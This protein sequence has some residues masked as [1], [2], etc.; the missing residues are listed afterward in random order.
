MD[1]SKLTPMMQQ[2]FNIKKEYTDALLFFRL[3]DFYEMFFDDALVGSKALEI[4]LTRRDCGNGKKCPMC[5][6]PYHVAEEYIGKLVAKGFK[7]AIC[8]QIEDPALAKGI[9]ERKVIQTYSPGMTTDTTVLDSSKNNYLTAIFYNAF[10]FGLSYIDISTGELYFTEYINDLR[11]SYSVLIS[12]LSKISPS[13]LLLSEDLYHNKEFLDYLEHEHHAVINLMT[14]NEKASYEEVKKYLSV[15]LEKSTVKKTF[16]LMA[17]STL[18]EY[19]FR[20]HEGELIH[21]RE[22]KYYFI[23]SFMSIDS[24]SRK[25]LEIHQNLNTGDKRNTLISVLDKTNTSMGARLLSKY[26]ERPLIN[27]ESIVHRQEIIKGFVLTPMKMEKIR[28]ILK[29]I[30]DLERIMGKLSYARAN[31]KDLI[32]LKYSIEKLPVLKE[33]LVNYEHERIKHMGLKLDSLEDIYLLLDASIEDDPPITITEGGIIKSGFD[34]KLDKIRNASIVGREELIKYEKSER[35]KTGIRTLKIVYNKKTGYFIDVTK[36]NLS[37][38]PADYRKIQ[39]LTNSERFLSEKLTEIQDMIL[40]N[41]SETVLLEYEIFQKIRNTILTAYARIFNTASLIAEIDVYTNLAKVARDNH[42]IQPEIQ[43]NDTYEILDGRHPV[44]ECS[45]YSN[46]FIPNDCKIGDKDNR[47]HLITGPNMGGKSTYMRQNALL[48]IMAQIGSFIPADYAS[49]SITDKIFTR[50]GASDNLSQGESTF[51][52]EMK[53]MSYILSEATKHSFLILDEIGRGTSTYDGLSIAWSILEYLSKKIKAKTLFAT[54]YHELTDLEETLFNVKNKRVDVIE[55]QN[56]I[57]LLHKIVDGKSDK[58]YGIE[59]AK[60][61]DFPK[62]ILER[63]K[64]I[65]I[66]I[67][68][69]ERFYKKSEKEQNSNGMQLDLS[70]YRKNI[71]LQTIQNIEVNEMTPISALNQLSQIIEEAKQLLKE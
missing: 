18:L 54:H 17:L 51:M 41:E 37:K 69:N 26:L 10:G 6:I 49:L 47:I 35:E 24:N 25:N 44:V 19:V 58:S 50:I 13:E 33:I 70:A 45:M 2:Y 63:A 27:K 34:E 68:T 31:G 60:L 15:P 9:V 22:A 55:K 23:D 14:K 52:V 4:A 67:E 20:F 12:E 11:D 3:G 7:V 39:T 36:N 40:G 71:F 62:E 57:V 1:I 46:E 5:G 43:E 61:A 21:I 53:E 42:Y 48:I 66:E 32:A 16:A 64:E 65:L 8:E 56:H 59:V 38:V 28:D 29:Q 30:Y